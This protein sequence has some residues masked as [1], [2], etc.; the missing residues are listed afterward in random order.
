VA[1]YL[2]KQ[3]KLSDLE[4]AHF[5]K[6]AAGK[7]H[8]WKNAKPQEHQSSLLIQFGPAM[9]AASIQIIFVG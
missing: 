9:I 7:L 3:D 6:T 5:L 4:Y 1:E 8:V 2:S